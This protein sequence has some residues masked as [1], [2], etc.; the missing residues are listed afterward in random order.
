MAIG[1]LP[2]ALVRM[3]W[4]NLTTSPNTQALI[5]AVP[6]IRRFINYF[7]RNWMNVNGVFRPSRWN[8]FN[9][10]M[11]YRTNN[12][13]EAYNRAWNWFVGVRHP[14]LWTFLTKL[15]RRQAVHE[16]QVIN[17]INGLPA[18]RRKRKWRNL[19]NHIERLKRQYRRG[20]RTIDSYWNAITHMFQRYR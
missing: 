3:N 13:V 1:F 11:E 17:M 19:E 18:R 7:Q 5:A 15:K 6:A 9:R 14:S 20:N 4:V 12:A 8:V 2:L 10:P 16:V